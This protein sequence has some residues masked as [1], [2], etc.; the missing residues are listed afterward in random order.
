M[1]KVS[2]QIKKKKTKS[3]GWAKVK[4]ANKRSFVCV[5]AWAKLSRH[6][7]N[8][9]DDVDAVGIDIG[10]DGDSRLAAITA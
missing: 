8:D 6:I 7:G 5:C 2:I 10:S 4:Q 1:E 9:N 3:M